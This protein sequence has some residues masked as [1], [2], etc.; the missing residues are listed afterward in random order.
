[1]NKLHNDMASNTRNRKRLSQKFAYFL[2]AQKES[3]NLE[4]HKS[5]PI[6]FNN[7]DIQVEFTNS[8][9]TRTGIRTGYRGTVFIQDGCYVS[10]CQN[11]INGDIV[12]HGETI[13]SNLNFLLPETLSAT[14]WIGRVLRVQ[15]GDRIVGRVKM[16]KIFNVILDRD[17]AFPCSDPQQIL[18]KQGIINNVFEMSL[19][20]KNSLPFDFVLLRDYSKL[21]GQEIQIL[22]D[23]IQDV[24][25]EV[26]DLLLYKQTKK[27]SRDFYPNTDEILKNVYPWMNENSIKLIKKDIY[28]S[29]LKK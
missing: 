5:E 19:N 7:P 20:N 26:E 21:S 23:Y 18:T 11:F 3:K 2:N 1:M 24:V 29:F 9:R 4:I 28:D 15:E 6:D 13:I 12:N 16:R 27:D 17:L 25:A 22:A 10:G 8:R 14:L